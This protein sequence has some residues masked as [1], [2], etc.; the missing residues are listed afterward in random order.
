MRYSKRW[1]DRQL[2]HYIKAI[3]GRT[4]PP[5]YKLFK[6]KYLENLPL[7][8]VDCGC[9][10]GDISFELYK[11]GYLV[12]GI[13]YPEII[14]KTKKKFPKG[15]TELTFIDYD[16]NKGLPIGI[17]DF[18][19]IYASEILEHITHDFD[20]LVSCHDCL[21]ISGKIFVTVPRHAEK[22]EGHL[23]FYPEGSLKNMLWAAGFDNLIID[24]TFASLIIIGEKTNAR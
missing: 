6:E 1:H 8:I 5:R 17:I 19:W 15:L 21:K 14:F 2:E 24:K 13:D 16:L 10:G 11:M 18:D 23:R 3:E 4:D 9:A 7:K 12:V 20:F 22:W